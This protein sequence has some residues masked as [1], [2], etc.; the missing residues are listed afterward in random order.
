MSERLRR[1][2]YARYWRYARYTVETVLVNAL[3]FSML[4]QLIVYLANRRFWRRPLP[5]PPDQTPSISV[6]VP[7]RGKSLD[8]LALLH[9]IAVTGPTDDYEGIMVIEDEDDPAYPVAAE[10]AEAYPRRMRIVISGPAG[11][12]VGKIHNVNAGIQAARGEL[13]AL[14]DASTQMHAELWHAALAVMD[15]P[16]VGA[17]FAPPIVIEPET[18]G[19]ATFPAGGEM[20]TALHTNHARTAELPLVAIT[21]RLY[22]LVNGFIVLRRSA[23][24]EAGGLLHL[25]DEASEEVALARV[26]TEAGYRIAAIPVPARVVAEPISVNDATTRLQRK[27]IT[28]RATDPPRFAA[29]LFANPLTVGWLLGFITEREGR[30]WGRQTWWVFIWLRLAVAY[31]LDRIRFGRAFAWTA[32]AQLFM[33]DTFITPMLWARALVQRTFVWRGRTYRIMQGGKAH[34]VE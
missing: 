12:H 4:Y 14:I 1:T 11:Q 24:D 5:A 13:I 30:W 8:T 33:L 9:L 27:L 25:L 23:L 31:E 17:A 3:I 28:L 26:I 15:D 18:R 21:H 32:Y 29:L 16:G 19:R 34:R 7:L 22:T 10:I 6:V 2:R 20:L